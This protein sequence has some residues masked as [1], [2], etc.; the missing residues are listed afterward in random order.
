MTPESL[1]ENF[2]KKLADNAQLA[3]IFDFL[4]EIFFFAKDTEGRFVLANKALHQILGITFSS[5]L[6]GKTDYDFFT[7]SLADKYRE[8]DLQVIS[9][10][11]PLLDQVWLVPNQNNQLRWYLSSKSPLFGKDGTIIGVAGVMRDFDTAGAVLGPYE[12]LSKV[13][14]YIQSYYPQKIEISQIAQIAH[15]STS[16]LERRFK[17][18]FKITPLK[19]INQVRLHAATQLLTSTEDTLGNIA[20]DCGFYDQS[21]FTHQ[22]KK[23]QGISPLQYRKNHS[24]TTARSAP[25]GI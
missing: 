14:A 6:I 2:C 18:L 13:I 24:H 12:S 8:E 21:H 3:A 17:K 20:F 22:F 23:A 9:S 19:Y 4:P 5:E 25:K 10:G 11:K 16:Q 1:S 7:A 15:L